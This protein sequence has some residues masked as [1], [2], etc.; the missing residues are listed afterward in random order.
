MGPNDAAR[1]K[2]R[3][4]KGIPL[5]RPITD[6]SFLAA[7]V[8]WRIT[9]RIVMNRKIL[10]NGLISCKTYTNKN[11]CLQTSSVFCRQKY[12]SL[13]G[14][15][16]AFERLVSALNNVGSEERCRLTDQLIAEIIVMS[17]LDDKYDNE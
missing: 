13:V 11:L 7:S 2:E 10:A 14:S 5:A 12:L 6:N 16:V 4:H 15:S 8:G 9:D 3:R 1:Q 17:R